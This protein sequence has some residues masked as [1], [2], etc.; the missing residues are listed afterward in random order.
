LPTTERLDDKHQE[1]LLLI[2]TVEDLLRHEVALREPAGDGDQL[3][4]PTQLTRERKDLGE[5]PGKAVAY[6]FDGP[7]LNIYATLV[8]RLAHSGLFQ[9]RD[10][11]RSAATFQARSG[12]MC[13]VA[14]RNAPDGRGEL[15]LFY[16]SDVGTDTRLIFDG[17]IQLHLERKALQDTIARRPFFTCGT[18]QTPAGPQQVDRRLELGHDWMTCP[19]C[20]TRMSIVEHA[21]AERTVVDTA[22]VR[23]DTAALRQVDSDVATATLRGKE[24]TGEFDVFLAYNSKDAAAVVRLAEL[25]ESRG[26]RPW[27][28]R[29]HLPPG[30]LVSSEIARILP[31]IRAVA[32]IVGEPGIGRWE[33][34][35]MATAIRQFVEQDHK[36]IPVLLP[37]A[38]GLHGLP[39]F[40]RELR[41]VKFEQHVE[42][43][44][45]LDELQWGITGVRP[46]AS[47]AGSPTG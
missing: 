3:I 29:L 13:G 32:V 9:V 14:M 33:Q 7:L 37:G 20:D 2:A 43:P 40:L 47:A 15:T 42:E 44:V 31:T 25:L 45:V 39:S 30:V 41:A 6:T 38:Q 34:L 19:V 17:Y 5:P 1:Q 24:V 21:P 23:M 10:L 26:I 18:C 22:V 11:W 12:G 16:D 4:F 8:V 35:E 27:I 36:V 46:R 28:D